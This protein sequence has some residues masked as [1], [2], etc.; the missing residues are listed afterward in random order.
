MR[1]DAEVGKRLEQARKQSG[2]SL[3]QIA[4]LLGVTRAAVCQWQDGLNIPD[5]R[6][7]QMA[8]YYGVSLHWLRTGEPAGDVSEV[9][10]MLDRTSIPADSKARILAMVE[11]MAAA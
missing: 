10:A 4:N 6:L 8:D 2:L 9:V 1:I 11:S 5:A 7:E 3:S